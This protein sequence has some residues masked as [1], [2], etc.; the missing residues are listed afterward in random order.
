[1]AVRGDQFTKAVLGTAKV[2]TW[3]AYSWYGAA[4]YTYVFANSLW[5]RHYS[6]IP[7]SI[8]QSNPSVSVEFWRYSISEQTW[9]KLHSYTNGR[10]TS[11]AYRVRCPFNPTQDGIS[12]TLRYSYNEADSYLFCLRHHL[13][14]GEHDKTHLR[15]NVYSVGADTTYDSSVKGRLIYGRTEDKAIQEQTTTSMANFSLTQPWL[16]TTRGGLITPSEIKRMI[17]V[18]S[19]ISFN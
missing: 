17:S 9:I 19:A 10:D 11:T 1:M 5:I 4:Y 18:K 8:Y 13:T 2:Y 3:G 16:T 12:P 14:A 15:V 6:G 7:S